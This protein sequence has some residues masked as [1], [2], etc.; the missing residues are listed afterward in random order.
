M[1][2]LSIYVLLPVE[3]SICP[4]WTV[5]FI[6]CRQVGARGTTKK[7]GEKGKCPFLLKSEI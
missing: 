2:R 4:F 6:V 5:P 3:G 7:T 1:S